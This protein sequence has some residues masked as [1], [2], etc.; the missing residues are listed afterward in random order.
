MHGRILQNS[1]RKAA[2]GLQRMGFDFGIRPGISLRRV[3]FFCDQQD[4]AL[5]GV[6]RSCIDKLTGQTSAQL[7]AAVFGGGDLF[8]GTVGFVRCKQTADTGKRQTELREDAQIRDRPADDQVILFP[9]RRAGG[10]VFRAG[11]ERRDIRQ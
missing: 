6:R 7:A 10:N 1:C 11:R 3:R 5:R 4:A 8:I 2:S 9:V